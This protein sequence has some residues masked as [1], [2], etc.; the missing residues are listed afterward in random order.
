MSGNLKRVPYTKGTNLSNDYLMQ[1][2]TG[3]GSRKD[4]I[5]LSNF[6]IN[7]AT[8]LANKTQKFIYEMNPWCSRLDTIKLSN[9]GI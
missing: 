3:R 5:K 6:C 7:N 9:F 4:A 8:F 1:L 2:L